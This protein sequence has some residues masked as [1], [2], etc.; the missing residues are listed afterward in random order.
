VLIGNIRHQD[1]AAIIAIASS[2]GHPCGGPAPAG[3]GDHRT[4][5]ISVIES[6][7]EGDGATIMVD[8]FRA[9]FRE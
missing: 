8:P 9:G 6:G 3:W 7:N 2:F 4:H 1:K 5:A